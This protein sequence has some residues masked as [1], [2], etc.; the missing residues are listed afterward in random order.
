M[1]LVDD[2]YLYDVLVLSLKEQL[3]ANGTTQALVADLDLTEARWRK[4]AREAGKQL[5][6]KVKTMA[7]GARLHAWLIDWP[8]KPAEEKVYARRLRQ[9]SMAAA[10]PEP[11]QSLIRLV[12][13][14]GDHRD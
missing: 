2:N 10:L 8:A 7:A 1:R 3:S 9:A 14:D 12:R 5:D 13:T 11:A 4:A 6:R